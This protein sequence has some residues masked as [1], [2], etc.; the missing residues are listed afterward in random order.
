MRYLLLLQA[1][2][3]MPTDEAPRLSKLSMFLAAYW[4]ILLPC[5]LAFI[6]VYLLLP[7][8]RRTAPVAGMLCGGAALLL[9]AVFLIHSAGIWQESLLFYCFGGI[10]VLAGGLMITQSNPVYAA[11]SF[12]LVVL[13]SCG[14]FLL[15]AAPFLMAA[16]IIIYAGAIVVTFL[17]VIMLAQQEGYSSADLRS[18]EPFLSAAAGFVLLAATLVTV[19]KAMATPELDQAIN[20]LQAINAAT[21]MQDINR[22]LGTPPDKKDV[23]A[24]RTLTLVTVASRY[25]PQEKEKLIDAVARIESAWIQQKDKALKEDATLVLAELEA[26]RLAHGTLSPPAT[27]PGHK[28][29][30]PGKLPHRN[31]EGLGR[32]LFTDYLVPVEIA[33]VLLLVAT[34]GAIV[35]AGRHTEVLR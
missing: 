3:L 6:A 13:S 24:R 34:I 4:A 15:Q 17:F 19:H 18:R 9:G 33:A 12:A 32:L 30:M 23:Q 27:I 1:E 22:V 14:L 29:L 7:R 20:Q 8:T 26:V 25:I 11:L 16:T 31:V 28:D 35:I 10:A 5:L 2:P 21:S